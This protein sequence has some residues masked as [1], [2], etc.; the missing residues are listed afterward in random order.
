MNSSNEYMLNESTLN[1]DQSSLDNTDNNVPRIDSSR[2]LLSPSKVAKVR[3]QIMF[4]QVD[5]VEKIY[6][7]E[8]ESV[9]SSM[10]DV[11]IGQ[12]KVNVYG[13]KANSTRLLFRGKVIEDKLKIN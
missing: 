5:G 11:T 12:I 8:D 3:Y 13:S 4:K 9:E 6:T 1:T 10:N 2:D 7:F